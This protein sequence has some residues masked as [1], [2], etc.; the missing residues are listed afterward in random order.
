MEKYYGS[1]LNG[2]AGM[3]DKARKEAR[4]WV[5]WGC[6][7]HFRCLGAEHG[8][9][10]VSAYV[11]EYLKKDIEHI[12]KNSRLYVNGDHESSLRA[13][14][15]FF[16][17]THGVNYLSVGDL[18]RRFVGELDKYKDT[19]YQ[20]VGRFELGQRQDGLFEHAWKFQTRRRMMLEFIIEYNWKVVVAWYRGVVGFTSILLKELLSDIATPHHTMPHRIL[21]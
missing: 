6:A 7:Q 12:K 18:L 17:F 19:P 21:M 5:V 1:G 16:G 20:D 4:R 11:K 10:S 14:F 15:K 9:K 13:I 2:W 3:D 8:H